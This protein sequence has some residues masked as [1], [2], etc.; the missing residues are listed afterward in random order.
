MHR[1]D[2][3]RYLK[4][5]KNVN[6][7]R[8]RESARFPDVMQ[9]IP[10]AEWPPISPDMAPELI[11]LAVWRSKK[12]FAQ[13]VKEPNGAVRISVNRVMMNDKYDYVDGITW[14]DLFA[15]KNQ[16]GFADR[17]CIEIY[18]AQADLVNVANIRHLF[19]LDA[20]H[21]YNWENNR[22][23]KERK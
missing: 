17:D 12:F 21:P 23:R 20:P 18:P 15:I 8:A 10:Q 6:R 14:D 1:S 19:V 9:E 22:K 7:E 5:W 4:N 11:P 2:R 13:V 16:I 3:K